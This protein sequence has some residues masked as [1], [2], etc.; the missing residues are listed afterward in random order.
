MQLNVRPHK[1]NRMISDLLSPA[2]GCGFIR[3]RAS[4]IKKLVSLMLVF[5]PL[6]ML[7]NPFNS[8][9]FLFIENKGQNNGRRA[10]SEVFIFMSTKTIEPGI[11]AHYPTL[12]WG[13]RNAVFSAGS[14]LLFIEAH[15]LC[16]T[17]YS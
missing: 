16:L 12:M 3:K 8:T 14:S 6:F 5:G 2:L 4:N 11:L 17:H 7:Y 1:C 15:M 13:P 9:H 10:G